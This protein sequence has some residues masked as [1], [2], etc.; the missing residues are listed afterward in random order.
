MRFL[1]LWLVVVLGLAR[2]TE[3]INLLCCSNATYTLTIDL[4]QTCRDTNV[5]GYGI[6]DTTCFDTILPPFAPNSLTLERVTKVDIFELT[7]TGGIVGRETFYDPIS[8][9]IEYNSVVNLTETRPNALQVTL[10]AATTEGVTVV[11]LWDITFERSCI[12]PSLPPNSQIGW[13]GVVS[14]MHWLSTIQCFPLY[15]NPKTDLALLL[16]SLSHAVNCT[17]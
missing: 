17:I 2:T 3:A 9:V 10:T 7:A 15:R 14:Y 13:T 11:Q 5:G 12:M 1:I 6:R 4:S 16:R 8:D